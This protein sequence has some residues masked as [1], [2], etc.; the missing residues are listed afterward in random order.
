MPDNKV[1]I[2]ICDDN[3]KVITFIRLGLKFNGFDVVSAGSGLE[4]LEMVRKNEIDM[5]LQD[6]KMAGMN[7][8]DVLKEIRTFSDLPVIAYS[9]N[10]DYSVP[11]LESGANMFMPKP[12]D[13]HRLIK[14]INSL[15]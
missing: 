14:A 9:A 5:L 3:P 12:L 2:L 13:M 7:G 1:R 8:I 10:S 6:I 11:A 4:C 15:V